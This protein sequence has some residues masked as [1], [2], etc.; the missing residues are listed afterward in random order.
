MPERCRESK[1]INLGIALNILENRSALN[2][3]RI[4]MIR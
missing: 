4:K 1:D 3:H 2:G